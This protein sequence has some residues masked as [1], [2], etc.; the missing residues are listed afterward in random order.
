M[1]TNEVR[2]LEELSA[3]IE[4]QELTKEEL[5]K[6]LRQM[7][8]IR[9]F[10]D[11]IAELLGRAVLR[12]A[13]HLYAGEE[14]V[15]VG[16]MAA[17]REDDLVTSTHRG[18]GHAHAHGDNAA[19]TLEEKQRHYNRMMAEVLGKSGGYCKGKGGS[20]HIADVDHG[21]L[22]ATG[23]VGGNIPVAVGAALAQKLQGTDRVVLC[24]F[25]D[26]ASNTGN[27]HESLNMASLWDLPV[28]FVV[29]NNQYAMSVPWTKASK[30]QRISERAK[31]Y[32][33]PGETVDGMNPLTVRSEVSK[34][35]ARARRGEGPSIVE[36]MTYRW[37]GHSHSDPRA[38]RTRAEEAEWKK[39]DPLDTFSKGLISLGLMSKKEVD[40]LEGDVQNKLDTAMEYSNKSPEPSGG[41]LNTDVFAPSKFTQQDIAA[42]K[43]WR[44]KIRKGEVKREITYTQ[45]L[46]EAAR[47]EMN[48]NPKVFI[49]GEDVGLYG[50]AYGATRG[51]F[52]EF[53]EKRVIDTPISEA[54]IGGAA[55]GAAMAGMRPVAEIMYVDFTPLA[56]DQVANQGAKNRYMFGGKTSVPM[57]IRT[58][59]GAGRAIAAHHSQSLESL[60]TH[61]PGIYVVMPSTPY[62]AK[63]LL[64]AAIRDDNPVMFIEH[65]MLYK[66]K[67]PVPEEDYIIPFGVADIKRPGKDITLVTY[68]RMVLRALEAADI[69]A[70]EGIDVEVI[71]LRTLCPLDINTVA[72][73]V[74]KTGKFV[75]VTEAYE[76]TSFINEVMVQLNERV[77]DWLDAPMVRVAAANVP[78][79]RAE[80]LEDLAIPNTKRIVDA[81]RKVVS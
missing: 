6:Y 48:R 55:V 32:G 76:N 2:T 73:S 30:V 78:V 59:G 57:V 21:N 26:G 52:E 65:K 60:W 11:N 19:K 18:H 58:E 45:A 49:M 54:T 63:G 53:G 25:G 81:C 50:G 68:S 23:I 7:M 72:E 35:V 71:D 43:E 36:C 1:D 42:D 3:L 29:E 46:V 56:M 9:A 4:E 34:A 80:V 69:L 31:A 14:A 16:A 77:F 44:E 27:F 33:I 67:G 74:K 22:G 47:E 28:V 15:A 41:E 62:D 17:L 13:S 70:K 38:Y 39:R 51:L 8:E 37:Y 61:F 24:F 75:G 5:V 20:M 64:K 79:P 10:E 66:E 12:G 40:S